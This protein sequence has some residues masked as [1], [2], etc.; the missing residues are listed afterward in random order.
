[1][2][3]QLVHYS[4]HFLLPGLVAFLFFRSRWKIAWILM[5]LTMLVDLDHLF[6]NPI[7][8]VDRCGINFHPLHTYLAIAI[9]F[10]GLFFNKTR[11]LSVGLLL[12]M[13]T[14]QIDCFWTQFF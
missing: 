10:I 1:M 7:F 14:D 12:H 13:A 4:F 6:A 2:L 5:L 8:Q 3:Q 9:Y 11:I